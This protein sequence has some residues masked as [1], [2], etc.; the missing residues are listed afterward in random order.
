MVFQKDAQHSKLAE[1]LSQALL[2]LHPLAPGCW[3]GIKA[4]QS[5]GSGFAVPGSAGAGRKPHLTLHPGSLTLPNAEIPRGSRVYAIKE[6]LDV[7]PSMW[8]PL[9]QIL[10]A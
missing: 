3:A 7:N 8:F 4:V 5:S 1:L 6:S 10:V 9:T 2:G